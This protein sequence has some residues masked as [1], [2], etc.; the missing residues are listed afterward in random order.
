MGVPREALGL[1]ALARASGADFANTVTI[2]RHRLSMP[3]DL[4]VQFL[5]ERGRDDLAARFSQ[6]PGD[7]YCECL[8]KTAFAAEKVT[9]IDVSSY[10]GASLIHDMNTPIAP[11]SY[12]MVLDF[13]TLEHVFNVPVAF[14]NVAKLAA[15]GGYILHMLPCNNF[16]G[17]GFYQF[18]PEFFFQIYAPERGFKGTRVFVV[19][20]GAPEIWYE[21]RA[22]R[23]LRRRVD[24]TSREQLHLLVLTQKVGEPASLATCPVQQSD[25][26][27]V[28]RQGARQTPVARPMPTAPFVRE[29]LAGLRHLRKVARKSLSRRRSD[30]SRRR[31]RELV[32]GF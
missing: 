6:A 4:V 23:E 12:S 16:V 32:P 29:A 18:S 8:L 22:P 27:E 13:G 26:V 25:Y 2:G 5:Q 14:D 3:K 10:E 1:M 19:R 7:G 24:I 17:H 20:G 21:V 9:S 30:I 15:Q 11:A 31:L 28:W